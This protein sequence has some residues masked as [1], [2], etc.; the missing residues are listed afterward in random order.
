MCQAPG[1]RPCSLLTLMRRG[2]QNSEIMS[3]EEMQ[4]CKC[5]FQIL[6]GLPPDGTIVN[7]A[8]QVGHASTGDITKV[9][10]PG[11]S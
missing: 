10:Y 7:F 8:L 11:G 3:K 2:S 5:A 1:R 4:T 9:Q 6:H